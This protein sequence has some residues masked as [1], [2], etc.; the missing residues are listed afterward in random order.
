MVL[1]LLLLPLPCGSAADAAAGAATDDGDFMGVP[2]D[3]VTLADK[4]K[5]QGY[6]TY[7]AGKVRRVAH[8]SRRLAPTPHVP[9]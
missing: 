2:L 9:T 8:R 7:M 3:E 5:A 6:R 1:S 4:L